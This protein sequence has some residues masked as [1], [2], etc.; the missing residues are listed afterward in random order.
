[1]VCHKG[2]RLPSPAWLGVVF[3]FAC[4]SL[5]VVAVAPGALAVGGGGGGELEQVEAKLAACKRDLTQAREAVNTA[6]DFLTFARKNPFILI[7][8][9]GVPT[10]VP[11]KVATDFIILAYLKGDRT[12]AQVVAALQKL[13]RQAAQ[14]RRILQEAINEA[15]EGVE[16]TLK[17]CAALAEQR[18]RLR[19]GGGGGGGGGGGTGA[20]P[21]GTA[22][23][24]TLTIEGHTGTIDLK[25]G[26]V[27][28]E[29]NTS[30]APGTKRGTVS[31]SVRLDGTLPAGWNIYVAAEGKIAHKGQGSFSIKDPI[32]S[33]RRVGASAQICSSPP[34]ENQP[35]CVT[36]NG[37]ANMTVFWVWVP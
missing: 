9:D 24:M 29:G 17:R 1:M 16:K 23:K 30:D 28:Y 20:F 26:K 31:G 8:V 10:P 27:A 14:T 37:R 35:Y 7:K 22:T 34:A 15:R 25:T 36:G 13:A 5:A 6:E 32:G 12:R 3:A 4:L 11:L 2:M 19:A 18:D 21:P 33:Q